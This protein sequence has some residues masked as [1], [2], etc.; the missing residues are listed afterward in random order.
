M[1]RKPFNA[2]IRSR[3]GPNAETGVCHSGIRVSKDA[4]LARTRSTHK[5]TT[6][7]VTL[8]GA[9]P[10]D[11]DLLTLKAVKALAAADV[12]LVDALVNPEILSLA[13]NAQALLVG[14]RGGCMSTSQAR[15]EHTMLQYA[16]AGAN[17][18]RV[19]GGDPLLFG[20]AAE[21][22]LALRAH[23]IDIEI[24]NGISAGF[25]AAARLGISLTHR[26]HAHGVT[27]VSAHLKDHAE[28]D[29]HSLA[30]AGT[31][32]VI[33]MGMQRVERIAQALLREL[34]PSTPASVVQAVGTADEKVWTGQLETLAS[35]VVAGHFESPAV[36]LVG[37]TIGTSRE[38]PSTC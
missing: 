2:P 34:K 14:K 26:G 25:A 4:S 9:G 13:P 27:F 37:D 16:M 23:G 38:H 24:V 12:V 3:S 6:G 31:T 15:I 8:L 22:C 29:W 10:G 35:S 36:I 11:L 7:K 5:K 1:Q 21:E 28:P 19:K 32:L 17:V 18:V 20:R 33:Y 30:Q